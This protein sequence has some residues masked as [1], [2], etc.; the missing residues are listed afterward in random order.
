LT[1]DTNRDFYLQTVNLSLSKSAACD[2]AT[3]L[4]S[5]YSTFNG[6][7]RNLIVIAK[8]TLTAQD[9]VCSITFPKALK[10]DRGAGIIISLGTFTAGTQAIYGSVTGYYA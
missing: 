2:T 8:T 9:S 10:V 7:T 1:V 6:A 5:I 3:G 4:V